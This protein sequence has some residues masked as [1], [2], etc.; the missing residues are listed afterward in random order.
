MRKSMA[1]EYESYNDYKFKA[2]THPDGSEINFRLSEQ[3]VDACMFLWKWKVSTTAAIRAAIY[4]KRTIKKVYE[5]LYQLA[6]MEF[7]RSQASRCGQG[8]VWLLDENGFCFPKV[9][10]TGFRQFGY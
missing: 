5:R 1:H 9:R 10:I 2:P 4:P 3:D 7:I 8:T 6:E